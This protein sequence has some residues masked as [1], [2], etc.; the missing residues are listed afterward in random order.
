MALNTNKLL[1]MQQ[2]ANTNN[3]VAIPVYGEALWELGTLDED[4][5]SVHIGATVDSD[6]LVAL[7]FT[8]LAGI[9][10]E[11]VDTIYFSV[12]INGVLIT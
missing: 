10:D 2:H 11:N 6:F 4:G 9:C 5:E 12:N 8:S 3:M 7:G 1:F